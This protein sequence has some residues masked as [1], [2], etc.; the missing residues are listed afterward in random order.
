M[1][2]NVNQSVIKVTGTSRNIVLTTRPA[3]VIFCVGNTVTMR[4]AGGKIFSST[5]P[6]ILFSSFLLWG[7]IFPSLLPL[8]HYTFFVPGWILISFRNTEFLRCVTVDATFEPGTILYNLSNPEREH[9][10]TK[11]LLNLCFKPVGLVTCL[12]CVSWDRQLPRKLLQNNN[13]YEYIFRVIV[14]VG[15][16]CW[17]EGVSYSIFCGPVLSQL[18]VMKGLFL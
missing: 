11:S 17:V 7:Q 2:M 12:F 13:I 18:S 16:L 15:S 1:A 10:A 4:T 8:I 14:V 6:W 9:W 3:S 5:Y